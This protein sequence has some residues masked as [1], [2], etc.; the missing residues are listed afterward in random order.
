MAFSELSANALESTIATKDPATRNSCWLRCS[1]IGLYHDVSLIVRF[2]FASVA[3]LLPLDFVVDR[4]LGPCV[5]CDPSVPPS[6]LRCGDRFP[7]TRDLTRTRRTPPSPSFCPIPTFD[8][9]C[10]QPTGRLYAR[11][12]TNSGTVLI[13]VYSY[14]L[15]V[16]VSF[17]PALFCL[18]TSVRDILLRASS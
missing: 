4:L 13:F 17:L 10:R 8:S 6:L 3:S 11:C 16:A 15:V 12:W 7:K 2:L 9:R 14:H 18:L 5:V 1:Y